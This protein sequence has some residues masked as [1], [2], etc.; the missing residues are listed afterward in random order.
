MRIRCIELPGHSVGGIGII[1]DDHH[2]FSGDN[3]I[4]NVPTIT[5]LPGGSK[6]SYE[7]ITKVFYDN[8]LCGTVI[9]P[10]HGE[11]VIK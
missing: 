4:P 8:L 10:G 9:Y 11:A 5:R 7:E 6:K 1:I 2:V 3:F